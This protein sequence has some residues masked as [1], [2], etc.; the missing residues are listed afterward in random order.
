MKSSA[1]AKITRTCLPSLDVVTVSR[2]CFK[3]FYI[4]AHPVEGA[5]HYGMFDNLARFLQDNDAQ[6]VS[7][8]VFNNIKRLEVRDW[9]EAHSAEEAL[10][11]SGTRATDTLMLAMGNA[12]Q[13]VRKRV[14]SVL[15]RVGD[16]KAIPCLVNRSK[17]QTTR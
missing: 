12:D 8:D 3:K 15:C 1:P 10:I 9:R 11:A 4:T 13:R 5:N 17:L 16:P 6:I 2:R 7:Q 14:I